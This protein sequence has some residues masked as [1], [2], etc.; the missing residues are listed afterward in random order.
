[1]A[2]HLGDE[3]YRLATGSAPAASNLSFA[4]ELVGWLLPC[5][6]ESAQCEA[7]RAAS[8]PGVK[9]PKLPSPTLPLYVSVARSDSLATTLTGQLLALLTGKPYPHLNASTCQERHFLWMGG[10]SFNGICIEGTAN[11]SAAVSPAFVIDGWLLLFFFV[12]RGV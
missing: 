2:V 11:F 7:F 12:L 10:Y 8:P 6:L 5:Y 9:L 1:M 3:L 4:E